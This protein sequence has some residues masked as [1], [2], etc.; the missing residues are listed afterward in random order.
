[1]TTLILKSRVSVRAKVALELS[2]L[3][4]CTV[5]FLISFPTRV[6][7]VDVGLA[8]AALLAIGLSA[9]YT[10]R[11]V[12]LSHAALGSAFYYGI[13]GQDLAT[14]WRSLF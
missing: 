14:E 3:A 8:L 9:G 12:A 4:L 10:K 1:V 13:M 7:T 5:A 11:V 2:I 6:R